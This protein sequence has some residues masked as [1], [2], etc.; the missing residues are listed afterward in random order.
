M[1]R[2]ILV[3]T[4]DSSQADVAASRAVELADTFDATLHAIY[5]I[6]S[7]F[8]RTTATKEP[9]KQAGRVVLDEIDVEA[10]RR[11]ISVTTALAEG[12]PADQILDYADVHGV[13]LIAI[14]GKSKSTAE[15]FF[16]GDTTEKVVRHAPMS[17]LVVRDTE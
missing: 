4:D 2:S 7:R 9:Y 5:V 10:S 14:G 11:D 3:A 17:V 15:R 13:D 8:G 12:R 6:N 16:I 1:Y